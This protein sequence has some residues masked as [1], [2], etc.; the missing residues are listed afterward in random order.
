MNRAVKAATYEPQ[1][2][3]SLDDKKIIT[4][5][6]IENFKTKKDFDTNWEILRQFIHAEVFPKG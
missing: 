5:H 2:E 4:I 1:I 6:D 3:I